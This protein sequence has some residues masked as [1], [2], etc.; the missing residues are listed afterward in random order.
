VEAVPALVR[1]DEAGGPAEGEPEGRDHDPVV[2]DPELARA[3]LE[4]HGV[5]VM[6]VQQDE[7]ADA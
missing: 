1:G 3:V 5:A 7:L 4:H 2:G 6:G